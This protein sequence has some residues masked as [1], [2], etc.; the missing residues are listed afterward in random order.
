M[1]LRQLLADVGIVEERAVAAHPLLR[2][3]QHGEVMLVGPGI[4]AEDYRPA[5]RQDDPAGDADEQKEEQD[6]HAAEPSSSHLTLLGSR[7][8]PSPESHDGNEIEGRN[9]K[10]RDRHGTKTT[11][12]RLTRHCLGHADGEE[13]EEGGQRC[14]ARPPRPQPGRQPQA[15]EA[16]HF[17]RGD[18][19]GARS[20]HARFRQQR[21]EQF[22]A[23]QKRRGQQEET[24][25]NR[26]EPARKTVERRAS[27]PA[28]AALRRAVLTDGLPVPFAQVQ[29]AIP[30]RVRFSF[31]YSRG[32]ATAPPEGC[33]QKF[34]NFFAGVC[35]GSRWLVA[36]GGSPAV[37]PSH[38][39]APA[40]AACLA[41]RGAGR[42]C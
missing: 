10:W 34:Y 7:R 32:Y 9:P 40:E 26:H 17:D 12:A 19:E 2:L 14:P 11:A 3:Q 25:R 5:H 4:S 28:S 21:H 42:W 36:T 22:V 6:R 23:L 33:Q 29:H 41:G 27:S 38:G 39:D 15:E 37:R 31:P 8:A 30:L 16:F 1:A 20:P 35:P 24:K 18:P 13:A